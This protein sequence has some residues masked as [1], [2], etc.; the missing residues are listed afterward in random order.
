MQPGRRV[1][2]CRTKPKLVCLLGRSM[3]T[4]RSPGGGGI[5]S[6]GGGPT[7]PCEGGRVSGGAK[8]RRRKL[9]PCWFPVQQTISPGLGIFL[10]I[11]STT[12]PCAA[13]S[14][15]A[16]MTFWCG[17]SITEWPLM[18]VIS[19]PTWRRPSTS[20]APPGTIA[21]TVAWRKESKTSLD[22][23]DRG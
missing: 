11:L 3:R 7:I 20:A 9:T 21:P 8:I 10:W 16:L 17:A 13:A 4:S 5:S 6:S 15:M 19:S 1:L 12:S 2:D 23:L 18:C 14:P 22:G